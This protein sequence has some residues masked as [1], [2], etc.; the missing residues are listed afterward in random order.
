M[1]N[2]MMTGTCIDA[3]QLCDGSNDCGDGDPGSDETEA[4]CS[5]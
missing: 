5:M 1:Y 3:A 2:C 4:V